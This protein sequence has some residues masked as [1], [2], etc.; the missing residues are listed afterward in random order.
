M[1][2]TNSTPDTSDQGP[3][4]A[5][6]P[7][8]TSEP[9]T[10]KATGGPLPSPRSRPRVIAPKPRVDGAHVVYAGTTYP[11]A[12]AVELGLVPPRS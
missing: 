1:A 9:D 4:E 12:D 7:E 2:R 10:E 6:A 11:M 5:L 3:E 8:A